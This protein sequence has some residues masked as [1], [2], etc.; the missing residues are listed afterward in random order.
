LFEWKPPSERGDDRWSDTSV[1][2][3]VE[4]VYRE[5]VDPRYRLVS[6][7]D[8][9]NRTS[10]DVDAILHAPGVQ[11]V[12]IE[13]TALEMF[14]GQ[15]L[16]QARLS[17][18]LPPLQAELRDLLPN[19]LWCIIPTMSFRPGS[20]WR[21]IT[22]RIVAFLRQPDTLFEAGVRK[23]EVADVPFPIHLK[24]DPALRV[25]FAFS[26]LAPPRDQIA[27]DLLK[28]VEK[29]LSHKRERLRHYAEQGHRTAVALDS[30]E[31]QLASW[32]EPYLAFLQA[33]RTIGT[34]HVDD[35]FFCMT[36]EPHRIYCAAFKGDRLFRE[37]LNPINLRFGPEH[38]AKWEGSGD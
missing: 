29:A 24:F 20:D 15:L 17:E 2:A 22:Q 4:A 32:A 14:E 25:P 34:D 8:Q 7:P 3:A 30:A 36:S 23:Y 33:E 5:C 12:A 27:A 16:E 35:V 1:L 28:S 9:T 26:V 13:V 31:F 37:A 19:G 18:L 10:P 11:P 21:K 38:L 6:R